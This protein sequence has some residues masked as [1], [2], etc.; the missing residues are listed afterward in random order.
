MEH[1]IKFKQMV[2]MTYTAY[3]NADTKE[4]ALEM[5]NENPFGYVPEDEGV[6]SEDGVS[7][8]IISVKENGVP[9]EELTELD[10]LKMA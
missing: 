2:E 6:D 10:Q 9:A 7:L 8:E 1:A 3:V 5:F 4:E